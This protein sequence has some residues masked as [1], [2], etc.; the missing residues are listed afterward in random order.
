MAKADIKMPDEFLSKLSRLGS[1]TDSIA[2]KVLQAG[3]EIALEKVK[4]N[5]ADVIGTGTKTESRSTGELVRSI[6]LSPVK[7][8]KNGN[9]DIKVGFSEP[10]SD[11]NSNAKIANILEYGTS[12]QSAK[13]FM[14]P[15][16]S[17]VKKRCIDAMKSAFESEVGKI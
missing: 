11:G 8:D 16:K 13:P 9:H 2:E 14:K 1:Q 12:T 17:A 15:A 4:S 3:G 7:V 10:R 6:G 5:L